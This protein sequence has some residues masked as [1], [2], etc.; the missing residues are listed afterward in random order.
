MS[1][2]TALFERTLQAIQHDGHQRAIQPEMLTRQELYDHL[3]YEGY[4]ARDKAY[5]SS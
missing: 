4:E 2:T 3:G 1:H 5:F